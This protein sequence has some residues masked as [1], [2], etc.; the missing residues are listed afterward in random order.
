MNKITIPVLLIG[1][2]SEGRRAYK[3]GTREVAREE[4]VKSRKLA[5]GSAIV[6]KITQRDNKKIDQRVFATEIGSYE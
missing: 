3:V 4:R 6:M 1:E 2:D 5:L